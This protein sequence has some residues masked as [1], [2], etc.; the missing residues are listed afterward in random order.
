MMLEMLP[1]KPDIAL[2]ARELILE[3]SQTIDDHHTDAK[4]IDQ[5]QNYMNNL[6][7]LHALRHQA[8]EDSVSG[9]S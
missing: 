7:T 8:L 3:F 5:I 6:I 2:K 4:M 9:L 1:Y